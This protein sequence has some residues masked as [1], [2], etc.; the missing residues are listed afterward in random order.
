MP[1]AGALAVLAVLTAGCSSDPVDV[2]PPTI[3]PATAAASPPVTQAPD[4]TV[5]PVGADALAALVDPATRALVVLGPGPGGQSAVT[6]LTAAGPPR[7]VLTPEP[8]SAMTGAGDGTVFLAAR[9]GYLR[10]DVAAGTVDRVE[11]EGEADT[12]FTAIARR[13]DGRLVLGTSDGAVLTLGTDDSVAARLEIFARVDAL[14]TQG[15]T[16]VVLDR[17]QTSVTAVDAS[18][19]AA[20]AL[21]AGE[22]ATT[23]AADPQGRVLVAD[24]RGGELLVFGTDPLMMRQRYPVPDAPYGLAGSPE[25]AWVSQTAA[26]T[27]I[28]YDLST[29][30]PVEKVR[31]RTVQQPNLL[32]YDDASGTLYVV[33]GTGAGVQVISDAAG[34]R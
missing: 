16:T 14:V 1:L 9:G 20:Q 22:G 12:D 15:D 3:T 19:T 34:P 13:Q 31:Y 26:N 4:G 28:G 2:P 6:I 24:T 27:V 29:G 25:L 21:R 10:V 32:A 18:G 11:V 7:T 17:G 5:R 33:S 30:I 23:M 8:A